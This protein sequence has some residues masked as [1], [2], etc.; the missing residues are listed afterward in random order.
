MM[1]RKEGKSIVRMQDVAAA[2]GVSAATVS[3]A[4][5]DDPRISGE[6]RR[7]IK[8]IAV[9]LGYKPHPLVQA[10][11]TQ[12]RTRR[13]PGFETIALVT[14]HAEETWRG[15]DVCRWY[16]G[17]LKGQAANH[18]YRLEVFALDA[19][20]DDPA[21]LAEVLRARGIFGVI[22]AFSRDHTDAVEFPVEHFSV[23]GLGTY[24][25][26]TF[27]DRVHL[28]GFANVKLA[29]G[30]LRRRGYRRPGLLVPA[31]NNTV[32]GGLWTAAALDEQRG[33]PQAECC[34]PLV[35]GDGR[36]TQREFVAWF[37]AHRPDAILTYKAP[38]A[39]FLRDLGVAVPDEAGVAHLFGTETERA[40]TAGV[41]GQLGQ[42]G[43]AAVDLLVQKMGLNAQ[44]HPAYPRDIL[45]TGSWVDGPTVR[46]PL[47]RAG[48]A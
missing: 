48:S 42:V 10:L 31:H 9:R 35:V 8:E 16:L 11:M 24:F 34:A 36:R 1:D 44:G 17:G 23:V 4:L 15:K 43:A 30:E 46:L 6:S 2:A 18:G 41:D 27:V 37:Q 25:A 28:N 40:G 20:G 26:R 3:R 7:R 38:V 47:A 22:L 33:R 5:R 19:F 32:V 29:L 13:L 12:R 39:D 45:I 21:R 14:S